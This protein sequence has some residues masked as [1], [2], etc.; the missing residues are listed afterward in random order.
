[1]GYLIAEEEKREEGE[2]KTFKTP[3]EKRGRKER[4]ILG[5]GERR[6]R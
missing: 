4:G 5:K 3:E 6:S 1:M 2:K